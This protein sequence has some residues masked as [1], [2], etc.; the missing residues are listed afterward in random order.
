[1]TDQDFV[2]FNGAYQGT[3]NIRNLKMIYSLKRNKFVSPFSTHGDRVLGD[4][5]Y[6][7]F[8]GTYVLFDL[9]QDHQ[10]FELYIS[11][12]KLVKDQDVEVLRK[13]N[14]YFT[15][16]EYLDNSK[17]A[18]D[19]AR[20]VPGYHF[21]RHEDL[22]KKIYTEEDTNVLLEFLNQYDGKEFSE[23]AETE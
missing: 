10:N 13:V 14:I 5:E 22:Y 23:E 15:N 12:V 3:T 21:T 8:P 4:I 9:W 20:S 7:V 2:I 19:F 18:Y 17:V 1:M 11:L 6:R 16:D